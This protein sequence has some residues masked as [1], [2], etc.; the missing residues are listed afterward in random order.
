MWGDK[1]QKPFDT[2]KE[3]LTEPPVLTLPNLTDHFILDT[4]ASEYAIGGELIQVQNGMEKVVSYGSY[5]LTKE[6]R[7][8]CTTRK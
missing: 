1:Q 7:K 8:Y 3:S 2:L 6:Q 4:D 5:A